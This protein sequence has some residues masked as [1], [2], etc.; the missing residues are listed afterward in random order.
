MIYVKGSLSQLQYTVMYTGAVITTTTTGSVYGL[1]SGPIF[2][3]DVHCSGTE[4]TLL[5][6]R[7]A[8]ISLGTL[9][10]HNRDVGVKCE[11]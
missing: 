6:C 7:H 4:T 9:C 10:T 5:D 1:G 2:L 11:G 3:A 8:A